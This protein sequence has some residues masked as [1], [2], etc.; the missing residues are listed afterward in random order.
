M[1]L[2]FGIRLVGK[3]EFWMA[4]VVCGL[5][6]Y[7]IIDEGTG[8]APAIYFFEILQVTVVY[9]SFLV[10]NFFVV[11][12]FLERTSVALGIGL[13]VLCFFAVGLSFGSLD[14]GFPALSIFILYS[15]LKYGA[16]YLWTNSEAIRKKYAFL[17]PGALLT[18]ML[19]LVSMVLI[20]VGEADP[21]M[22]AIWSTLIPSGILL[23]AFSFYSLIPASSGKSRP[24]LRYLIKVFIVLLLASFPVALIAGAVVE[25]NSSLELIVFFNFIVQLAIVAPFSWVVYRRYEQRNDEVASLQKEL[26]Q[27]TANIDFLRSQINPHF[28]FNAL[29]TLYGT[30]IRERAETTSEGIQK[31]GDMM[32]FMLHENLQEKISLNREIEYLENYISLQR[33]R[34]DNIA[35]IEISARIDSAITSHQ[36]SPMLL[37]PFVENAFKHGISFRELSFI[38]ISL[39]VEGDSLNFDV[40]NSRHLPRENDPERDKSGIGLPNVRQRL[41]LL[42]PNRHELVIRETRKEFFVHLSIKLR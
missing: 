8:L 15:G 36:I 28:L 2:N 38:R 23:Y 14:M 16:L 21:E 39:E 4:S 9:A 3:I 20:I 11:P 31:L 12:R 41:T 19:W 27:S 24:F 10:L 25:N 13:I 30:A 32:R 26:G 37:I 5:L 42:Y 22:I 35:G 6:L 7:A 40:H 34:T 33:L 17:A 1:K 18:F 29:N